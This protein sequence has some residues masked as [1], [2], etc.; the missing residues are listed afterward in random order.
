MATVTAPPRTVAPRRTPTDDRPPLRVVGP[1]TRQR[2]PRSLR[3]TLVATV[4]LVL[5]SLLAVAVVQA[6]M[7]GQQV[8]LSQVQARLAVQ[9]GRHRDLEQKVAQLSNP[10]YVVSSA[11]RQGLVVPKQVTDLPQVTVPGLVATRAPAR[12]KDS[13]A[14]H[15][16]SSR[17]AVAPG[18]T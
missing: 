7:T 4:V 11:Q 10:S 18:R 15:G 12:H 9:S 16:G 2:R 13:S 8:T 3:P 5:G 6:Y 14:A 17:T 1:P